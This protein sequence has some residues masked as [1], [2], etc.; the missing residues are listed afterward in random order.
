MSL[1]RPPG[2]PELLAQGHLCKGLSAMWNGRHRFGRSG[3]ARLWKGH[4]SA[5]HTQEKGRPES[6]ERDFPQKELIESS[7]SEL[8]TSMKNE[9]DRVTTE[10]QNV[11]RETFAR[12]SQNQPTARASMV[13]GDSQSRESWG[14][15]WQQA[16]KQIRFEMSNS[17]AIGKTKRLKNMSAWTT[18]FRGEWYS[19]GYQDTSLMCDPIKRQWGALR[20]DRRRLWRAK[21]FP[22]V[23]INT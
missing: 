13:A 22:K 9:P 8:T 4:Y 19:W 2:W 1:Q 23:E 11:Y 21:I 6:Q 15:S 16:N 7:Q 20:G 10:V 3:L 5:Y 18:H 14:K 17:S 12:W